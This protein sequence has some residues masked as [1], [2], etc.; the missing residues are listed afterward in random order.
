MIVLLIPLARVGV[1]VTHRMNGSSA[2]GR[3]LRS[4]WLAPA[5]FLALSTGALGADTPYHIRLL[6]DGTELEMVGEVTREAAA[7]IATMLAQN[8]K[9]TVLQLTSEG[10]EMAAA[11]G[12]VT[13]V[14]D[15]ALTTYVPSMCVSACTLVFLSGRERYVS[16]EAKLGFHQAIYVPSTTTATKGDAT[17]SNAAM[18]KWMLGQGVS[19]DFVEHAMATP[20][21]S[22]WMPTTD[23]LL[24]AH[25]ATA[26]TNGARFADPSFGRDSPNM[27]D[28]TLLNSPMLRAMQKADPGNY[29]RMRNELFQRVKAGALDA[30]S[31]A[32]NEVH[33]QLAFRQAALVAGDDAVLAVM[34]VDTAILEMLNI[35]DP[36]YCIATAMGRPPPEG[37]KGPMM[38]TDLAKRRAAAMAAVFETSV[39]KPQPAPSYEEARQIMENLVREMYRTYGD[40]WDFLRHP[41]LDP[42]RSCAMHIAIRKRMASIDLPDRS[43]L[44]RAMLGGRL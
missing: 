14:Q 27:V 18:K 5:A 2:A 1:V 42:Q 6:R 16:P 43:V 22:V 24:K 44:L 23:E 11:F 31:Q 41:D 40:E 12:L 37:D 36:R 15:R 30:E 7:E 39:A 4:L 26:V 20:H 8:P 32:L 25:V 28:Q 13:Q 3:A 34:Q 33:F 10:G 19:P 21:E 9:I 35:A 38:P 17:R 29:E